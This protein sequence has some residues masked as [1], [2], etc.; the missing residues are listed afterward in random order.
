MGQVKRLNGAAE[1]SEQSELVSDLVEHLLA[2]YESLP[3]DDRKNVVG[4]SIEAVAWIA[5][6]ESAFHCRKNGQDL[7]AAMQ[8]A[9]DCEELFATEIERDLADSF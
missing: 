7:S 8:R 6:T 3:I 2:K 1:Q 4:A 9:A 5:A